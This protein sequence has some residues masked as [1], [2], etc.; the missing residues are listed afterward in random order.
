MRMGRWPIVRIAVLPVPMPRCTR[1]GAS[2]FS[3]AIAATCTGG[4]RVPQMAVPGPQADPACLPCGQGQ[5]GVAVREDHLAVGDPDRV[6]AEAIR[7]LPP[8]EL[9]C[10][11][12][13]ALTPGPYP[14]HSL[15]H[16]GP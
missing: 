15:T 6:V 10:I 8:R 4:I 13:D 11:L 2:R 14:V 1:P 7:P 12:S 9:T 3:V 5:H 16:G